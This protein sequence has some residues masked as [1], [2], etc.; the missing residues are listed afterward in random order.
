MGYAPKLKHFWWRLLRG[1]LHTRFNL[2]SHGVQCPTV[3]ALYN[4]AFEDELHLFT[5]CAHAILC[6]KE[7]NLWQSR[8]HQFHQSG[9]FSSI[10]FCIISS[11]EETKQPLFAAILLSLWR[12]RNECIWENKQVNPMTSC[13]LALDMI[14]DFN[15]CR[16]MLIY[17]SYT[18]SLAYLG[19][20]FRNL[21][22]V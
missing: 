10:I 9:S 2:H 22:E 1:C 17:R 6:W 20:T 12:A 15:W 3:C 16:N 11:M 13:R 18:Y 7:V 8:E 19:E 4:V 5:D 14:R 21:A